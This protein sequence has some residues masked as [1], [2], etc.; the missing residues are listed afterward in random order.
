MWILF[1]LGIN[2]ELR[3]LLT[4]DSGPMYIG[5]EEVVYFNRLGQT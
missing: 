4:W 5:G 1:Q 2:L 3:W